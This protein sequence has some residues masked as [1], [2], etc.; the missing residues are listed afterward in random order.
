MRRNMRRDSQLQHA[1]MS[2]FTSISPSSRAFTDFP[3]RN[4]S[5]H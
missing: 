4:A 3:G 2:A 1:D 5:D